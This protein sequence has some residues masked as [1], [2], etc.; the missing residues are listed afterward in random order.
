MSDHNSNTSNA[1]ITYICD[2]NG[3]KTAAV[4]PIG[5]YN[6]LLEYE[7]MVA[8][9]SK[10]LKEASFS[11]QTDLTESREDAGAKSVGDESRQEAA[12][13][14]RRGANAARKGETE[15]GGRKPAGS[16][17]SKRDGKSGS[18]QAKH[19]NSPGVSAA[20]DEENAAD[21]KNPRLQAKDAG[22]D[23]VSDRSAREKNT[24]TE[25]KNKNGSSSG[26]VGEG[27]NTAEDSK[28]DPIAEKASEPKDDGEN[29]A[30]RRR[31][32]KAAQK[33]VTHD[34][35]NGSAVEA[36]DHEQE[37][38][39]SSKTTGS[40]SSGTKSKARTAGAGKQTGNQ[41]NDPET[42]SADSSP[43]GGSDLR[44]DDGSDMTSGKNR[45]PKTES[46]MESEQEPATTGSH[47]NAGN[48]GN[49]NREKPE[50]MKRE[51]T[52]AKQRRYA[53]RTK[54]KTVRIEDAD[55][56][57]L[58]FFT[59]D[60]ASGRYNYDAKGYVCEKNGKIY[61]VITKGSLANLSA[62]NSLRDKV[63]GERQKLID[64]KLVKEYNGYYRFTEDVYYNSSSMAASVVAGSNR[65]GYEAWKASDGVMLKVMGIV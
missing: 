51:S 15:A 42:G 12:A 3:D 53:S 50:E 38:P 48:N 13:E 57:S 5:R 14:S 4:V 37:T 58:R 43:N 61:F 46:A 20:G 59:R 27:A 17:K 9:F 28:D 36:Q 45:S 8:L 54:V 52:L 23:S 21:P 1:S 7:R 55:Y 34:A 32:L 56:I 11:D 44:T 39:I 6:Q 41:E 47:G 29:A 62:A 40:K 22:E 49:A 30:S 16:E 60:Y 10:E 64:R 19:D 26:R 65:S 31:G 25:R 18:K 2:S 33:G 35:E 63:K 24:D